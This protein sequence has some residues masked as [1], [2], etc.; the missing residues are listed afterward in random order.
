MRPPGDRLHFSHG[1]GQPLHFNP[2]ILSPEEDVSDEIVE[3]ASI[4]G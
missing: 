2:P 4:K 3:V 1:M